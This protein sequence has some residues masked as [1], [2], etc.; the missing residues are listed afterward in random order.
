[1]ATEQPQ[2]D[3]KNWA[4]IC[5]SQPDE[6][7]KDWLVKHLTLF[8]TPRPFPGKMTADGPIPRR[9]GPIMAR[10]DGGDADNF[11]SAEDKQTLKES[12]Y[13]VVVC[14]PGAAVSRWVDEAVRTFKSLGREHRTLCLIVRGEPYA[15]SRLDPI[16]EE[17]LPRAIKYAVDA[18]GQITD[19][20]TAPAAADARPGKDG[21]R[22]A[23][24]KLTAGLLRID[25]GELKQRDHD[26]GQIQMTGALAGA[27]LLLIFFAAF[28]TYS[29]IRANEANDLVDEANSSAEFSKS[30][31]D[32][33]RTDS[34]RQRAALANLNARLFESL[35]RAGDS[36][37]A[38]SHLAQSVRLDPANSP[39][40]KQMT[41]AIQASASLPRFEG[42]EAEFGE[43]PYPILTSVAEALAGG[44][45]ND[46]GDWK[47]L[48]AARLKKFNDSIAS[49]RLSA[50]V[51]AWAGAAFEKAA[52]KLSPASP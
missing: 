37:S 21:R 39:R 13:L 3:F 8:R 46:D 27:L 12:R 40:V 43:I 22:N 29:F 51:K 9:I 47:P 10:S 4:F 36:S 48:D 33:R 31:F 2:E 20:P 45:V 26:R 18:E 50:K 14:S 49:E 16:G 28:S 11:L 1:M 7:W 38:L 30:E 24:L 5:Y 32:K 25:F 52:G 23:F 17:C 15:S 35:S 34:D 19:T 6:R 44:Y 41:D 42:I